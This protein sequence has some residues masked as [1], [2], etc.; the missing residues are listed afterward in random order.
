MDNAFDAVVWNLGSPATTVQFDTLDEAED[1]AHQ[2]DSFEIFEYGSLVIEKDGY[3]DG[4]V[5]YYP[6][7]IFI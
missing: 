4:W 6:R 2:F 3:G 5:H 1:Y 7:P